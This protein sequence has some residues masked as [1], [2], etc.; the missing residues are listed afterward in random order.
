[1][2]A[3]DFGTMIHEVLNRAAKSVVFASG[4]E[5]KIGAL[6]VK[7]LDDWAKTRFGISPSLPILI[8]LDAAKHRLAAVAHVQTQLVRDKW[9]TIE[10]E[11]RFSMEIKGLK[12]TGTI[13]RIDRNEKTGQIRIIDYKTTDS[14]VQPERAHF[15]P[16]SDTTPDF[17]KVSVKSRTMQWSDLQ[18]PLYMTFVLSEDAPEREVEV[19]YFN[20]PKAV[21]DTAVQCWKDFNQDTVRSAYACA[22]GVVEAVQSGIFWPPSERIDPDDFAAL[23]P[24]ADTFDGAAFTGN[25]TDRNE[26]TPRR[27]KQ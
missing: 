5:S 2:D 4:D 13:D 19:A 14:A 3:A 16:V 27:R 6:L 9:S 15:G 17:A 25:R 20:I 12:V 7:H 18:L 23:S 24:G 21:N 1:M 26:G 8:S 22:V 10:T 11:R